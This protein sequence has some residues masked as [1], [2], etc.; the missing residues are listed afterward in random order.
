MLMFVLLFLLV[1]I[2][3]TNEKFCV[4]IANFH[5]RCHDAIPARHCCGEISCKDYHNHNCQC[6]P[7]LEYSHNLEHIAD[8]MHSNILYVARS[9]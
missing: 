6:F 1:V 5:L 4:N 2:V 9:S 8:F 7:L 3:V